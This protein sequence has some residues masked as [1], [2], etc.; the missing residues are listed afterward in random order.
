MLLGFVG[1][2]EVSVKQTLKSLAVTGLVARHFM[3][4]VVD[5]VKTVL[6]CAGCKV[7]LISGCVIIFLCQVI[8]LLHHG[9]R[10]ENKY[11]V[12]WMMSHPKAVQ[13]KYSPTVTCTK[14]AEFS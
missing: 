5:G 11:Y 10:I 6:L 12:Y 13:V 8:L 7:E 1:L 2:L 9:D 4:G 14:K 3:H